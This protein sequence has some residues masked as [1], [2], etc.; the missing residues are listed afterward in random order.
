MT[1][2]DYDDPL[3]RALY[4]VRDWVFDHYPAAYLLGTAVIL[5]S[6]TFPDIVSF[7]LSWSVVA[8]LGFLLDPCV[9]PKNQLYGGAL[10]QGDP[11]LG[12]TVA[13]TFD[14]GPGP[15]TAAI[16]DLLREH[17]AR[18][19]FFCIGEQAE[20][21]PE[22]VLRMRAEGHLIA[23]HTWSHRDLLTCGL[24]ESQ[25]QIVEG[26]AALKRITG[27][28]PAYFRHPRGFRAP[29]TQFQL[30]AHDQSAVMW[31]VN[32]RD[33]QDPDCAEMLR[34]IEKELTPGAIVL[35][36]DGR[37]KRQQTVEL[38][39]RLLPWLKERGYRFV[40]I[41]EFKGC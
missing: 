27:E 21:F 23:N 17:Q 29:W 40:R 28:A 7:A 11:A 25:R 5:Y 14:D 4:A 19:T 12:M 34:R 41:D 26:K 2:Y 13:L 15:E 6:L 3:S 39:R 36:H 32:P 31:S 16:L 10:I 8:I 22:L 35:L 1:T 20:R 33:F 37:E 30:R 18:A 24:R 38:V 9:N